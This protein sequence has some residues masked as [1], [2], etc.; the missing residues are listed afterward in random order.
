MKKH[1]L[2]IAALLLGCLTFTGCSD[3]SV[4]EENTLTILNYG[5]YFDPDALQ[6]FEEETGITIKYEE[7]ESPEE[8][9]TKYKAGSIDYDLLC[10][11]DYMIHKL[12]EEGEVLEMNYDNIPEYK[13]IDPDIIDSSASFDAE[14][15][16]T[17]PYFYGTVGILYDTNVVPESEV[18]TWDVLWDEKYTGNIVMPNS[19]RDCLLVPLKRLN[20]S[21]NETNEKHLRKALDLLFEQKP[22]V[23]A[24]FVDETADE[25]IAGNAALAVV[26]SGEAAY[27][28]DEGENLGYT[29]PEEGSNLWIDS[30]F[31]PKTCKNQEKAELFL[32]F[33]CREDI[34]A[35][36]F[37]YVYYATPHTAVYNSLD[38][39]SKNNTTIFPTQETI[40]NCEVYVSLDREETALYNKLW[41]ELK[42][43]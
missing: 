34:A 43:Y 7:Y 23:Y 13:N 40:D 1:I 6:I 8:M 19:V 4:E 5:K 38:E 17:L 39:E 15:K 20:Y 11:S 30:W 31:I 32:N 25:M 10:T 24:Y 27:A 36:N 42:S 41:K 14:H 29:V 9:Y 21:I 12:I 16:Y 18:Q 37:D 35:M 33:L 26:Y 28:Q 3:S 22:L 2:C